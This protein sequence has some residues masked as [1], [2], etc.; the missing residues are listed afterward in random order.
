MK[1]GLR[2]GGILS[3]IFLNVFIDE[4]GIQLTSS[5]TGCK[6]LGMTMNHLMHADDMALI[7]PSAK[8]LQ[9]L[10]H[11]CENYAIKRDNF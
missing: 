2:Q 7:A 3:R 11:T 9:P 10:L 5:N 1:N 8:G 4:L 6:L